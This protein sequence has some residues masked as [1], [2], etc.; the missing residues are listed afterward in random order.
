MGSITKRHV[1]D[2][3]DGVE[4]VYLKTLVEVIRAGSISRAADALCVTQPAVSR[5][6]KFLEEQYGCALLDRSG[7]QLRPTDAGR[8]VFQKAK[9]LLEIE[10]DL[11]AGLHRLEGKTRLSFSSTPAF[12][13]AHLP[14][15]LRGFMLTCA[16]SA[17][18]KFTFQTPNEIVQ[19]LSAGLFDAAVMEGATL[20]DLSAFATFPLPE[21]ETVFFSARKLG[22]PSPDTDIEALLLHPLFTRR[23][24]CCSRLLLERGLKGVGLDIS[25]FKKVIVLDDIHLLMNAVA[26]GEGISFLPRDML[27]EDVATDRLR[28]H[29]IQGFEHRRP[30][31]LVVNQRDGLEGPLGQLIQA[32]LMHF[33]L[34]LDQIPS[35]PDEHPRAATHRYTGSP[36]ACTTPGCSP[37]PPLPTGPGRKRA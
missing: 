29:L 14:Q 20:L 36:I 35:M 15:I 12:G 18:L 28:I 22:I 10:A 1:C 37:N 17:D 4:S 19:G 5:R 33:D 7:N 2:A 31:I 25:A 8:M 26:A 32:I 34:P 30:R 24:G 13:T 27:K 21:A 6:I 11:E 16:E 9:A 23:E 3:E